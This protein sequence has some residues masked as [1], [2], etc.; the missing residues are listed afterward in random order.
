MTTHG[1]NAVFIDTNVLIYA[2]L[3]LSPFHLTAV[4]RLKDLSSQQVD[5]WVSRQVFREYVSAMSRPGVL[6]GS[7]PMLS[8]TADVRDFTGRFEV[9]EDDART[10][11]KW[12]SLLEQIPTA[13][14]QVHNANI[15]PGAKEI[16]E[17]QDRVRVLPG[18]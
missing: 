8:L 12:L 10:T 4:N 2:K 14:K 17:H 6:T 1:G 16:I 18:Y 11:A 15:D 9:A 3:A 13:G 7:I 5:F